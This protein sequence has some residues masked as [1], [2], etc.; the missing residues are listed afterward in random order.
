M[1]AE[2][3][4]DG[5]H[6]VLV[7]LKEEAELFVLLQ[8]CLVLDNELGVQTLQFGFERFCGA[9]KNQTLLRITSGRR[10]FCNIGV[11]APERET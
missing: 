10:T 2:L 11:K 3:C 9:A 1:I 4:H 5:F 7:L 6:S 8:Q